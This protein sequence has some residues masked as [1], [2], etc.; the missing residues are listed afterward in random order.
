MRASEEIKQAL[1][2]KE[3]ECS[4]SLGPGWEKINIHSRC[5][6][7]LGY[8]KINPTRMTAKQSAMGEKKEVFFNVKID[9]SRRL[10][11]KL[12]EK[13]IEERYLSLRYNEFK[14]NNKARNER[15]KEV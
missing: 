4:S 14:V 3:E 15:L 13:Q 11:V 6:D 12:L 7:E 8:E 10:P 5:I 9:N 2:I 1:E